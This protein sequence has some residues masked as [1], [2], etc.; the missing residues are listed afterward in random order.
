MDGNTLLAIILV[1][2]AIYLGWC[3]YLEYKAGLDKDRTKE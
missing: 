2:Y 3:R 1:A